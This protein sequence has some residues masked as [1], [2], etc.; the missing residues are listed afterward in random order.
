MKGAE[1]NVRKECFFSFNFLLLDDIGTKVPEDR[2]GDFNPSWKIETSP[3]N[4][5]A[6]II[7]KE[8]ISDPEQAIELQKMLINAGLCDLGAN[9]VGRWARLPKGINGKP[10]YHNEQGKPFQCLLVEWHP[11]RRYTPEEIISGFKLEPF[12]VASTPSNDNSPGPQQASEVYIPKPAENPV[13]RALKAQGLYKSSLGSGKHDITC[14]WCSEHTDGIDSGSAYFEPSDKYP[15]GGFCCQHSHRGKYR[16]SQLLDY[17]DI[18]KSEAQHK[19]IIRIVEGEMDSIIDALETELAKNSKYQSG[20]MIVSVVN[21]PITG[22][23]KM[24]PITQSVLTRHLSKIVIWERF[25]GRNGNLK[26]CDPPQKYINLLYDA[27]HFNHLP[28]LTGIARQPYFRE[29]DGELITAL[30]YDATSKLYGA[31]D[32]GL[33]NLPEPICEAA[34]AA[35]ELVNALL[36]EFHFKSPEDRAAAMSAIFTA[37][38]RPTLDRAPAYHVR[39][40]A[41][42]S[43]KSYLCD[44]IGTFAGPGGNTKVSYPDTSDEATKVILSLLM[45]SPPVV[46]FDDMATDWK[47]HGIINRMLTSDAITDRILGV[48]K[49]ATVYIRTLFLGSGNNVGPIRDLLRRV[50]T[51]HIDARTAAPATIKYQFNPVE[52][53]R[54]HREKYVSA[55]LTV[56]RAWRAAGCPRKAAE[57]IV[58]FDGAWSDYCRYPLMWLGMPDP[59]STL[60]AQV[61]HDPDAE[62]LGVLMREWYGVFDSAPTTIRKAID[63]TENG[64]PELLDALNELPVVERGHINRSK[65]GWF[66]KR[67]QNR[68][69]DG[70][71]FKQAEADG[72][73]A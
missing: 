60:L 8:A 14:P 37:V 6:G 28:V 68:I 44:L 73:K 70:Y 1:F 4:Y 53:V 65:L 39:A 25:D 43:G 13:I 17:L 5:Q 69:V 64:H 49:T 27:Q 34:E 50:L 61:K 59:A 22:A 67:N 38:V 72:R 57:H 11:E 24:L 29:S 18:S 62:A 23:V 26:R 36:D 46:E 45:S 7:L 52:T 9:G 55:V 71:E 58:T 51:I 54:K 19:P 32:P 47:P 48:S 2:L 20:G 12:P 33:Y 63:K 40:P 16:I 30:G 21:D 42:G 10:K 56:I 31:F 35:L 41:S 3:G 66:L 15:M